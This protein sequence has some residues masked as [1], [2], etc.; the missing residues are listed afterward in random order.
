MATCD[1][2]ER[3]WYHFEA[4]REMSSF[5]TY[6]ISKKAKLESSDLSELY[7]AAKD[8]RDIFRKVGKV[9]F[10]KKGRC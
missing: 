6:I 3:L 10:D 2:N 4:G 5:M 8:L 9:N 7:H 1:Q